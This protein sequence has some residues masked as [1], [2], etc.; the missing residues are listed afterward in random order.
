MPQTKGL[1]RRCMWFKIQVN[2][3]WTFD[4]LTEVRF[5][6]TRKLLPKK[7]L[8]RPVE[9]RAKIQNEPARTIR[10]KHEPTKSNKK[11]NSEDKPDLLII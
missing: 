8:F 7:V 10:W 3:G 5:C 4:G 1:N 9:A 2:K 11:K 6:A